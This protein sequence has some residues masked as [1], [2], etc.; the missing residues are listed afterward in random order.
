AA[1]GHQPAG[2]HPGREGAPTLRRLLGPPA[3]PGR[4]RPLLP[5]HRAEPQHHPAGA[6][7]ARPA[8][9][10]RRPH[11]PPRRRTAPR[12]KKSPGIVEALNRLVEHDTA[13]DPMADV[14]WTR[15]TTGALADELSAQGF[16]VSADTVAR[17]LRR[18]RYTLKA[19]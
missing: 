9:R 3:W 16:K 1:P 6:S 12:R 15:K 8:C 19:N 7:A 17:L 4:R 5:G 18:Q 2:R 14:R 11:P 10:A 13:G